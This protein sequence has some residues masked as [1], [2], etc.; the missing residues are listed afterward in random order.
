MIVT[1]KQFGLDNL[2]V[3]QCD[4]IAKRISGNSKLDALFIIDGDEG[5][6]KTTL[7]VQLAY[8]VAWQ[9][10]RPFPF[11]TANLFFNIDEMVKFAS[12]TKDQIIVWDEAALGGL[13]SEGYMKTQIKLLK[14]LMVARKKRHFYI[15]NIPKFY[16][17][18]EGIVDRA[19]ALVHV[20]AQFET[21]LGRFVYYNKATKEALYNAWRTSKKKQYRRFAR[22]RGKFSDHLALIIDEEEYDRRKDL[23]IMSIA[24]E[25]VTKTDKKLQ[26]FKA[27]IGTLREKLNIKDSDLC[28][29]LGIDIQTM[30]KW[31]RE[32]KV[33]SDDL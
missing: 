13:S 14:L 6:G 8:Y 23:A 9:T 17:L 1:D 33:E 16:R 29:A 27:L 10:G 30:Y 31:R 11:N 3:K 4:L 20:Y 32:F 24:T 28:T 7:A 26:H 22:L 18:K 5:Y 2:L 25:P 12:E 19:I 21:H 15:F